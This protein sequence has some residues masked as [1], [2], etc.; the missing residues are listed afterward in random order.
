MRVDASDL[1][2]NINLDGEFILKMAREDA[3]E[4]A[5]IIETTAAGMTPVRGGT[6]K[7]GW[8]QNKEGEWVWVVENL[9]PY[10]GFV[11]QGTSKQAGVHMTDN[12]IDAALKR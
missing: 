9:V 3:E 11:D 6:L 4:T 7:A 1:T 2:R 5:N 12:A 8:Q 10:A